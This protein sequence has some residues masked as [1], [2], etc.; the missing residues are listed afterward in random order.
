MKS[1]HILFRILI[2]VFLSMTLMGCPPIT[3]PTITDEAG[4]IYMQPYLAEYYTV[5]LDNFVDQETITVP[6]EFNGLPITEVGQINVSSENQV[7]HIILPDTI[8]SISSYAFFGFSNLESIDLPDSVERIG[9]GAF[10]NCSSLIEITIPEGVSTLSHNIFVGCISLE[11][12]SLPAS[13]STIEEVSF[14]Q[15]FALTEVDIAPGN[16]SFLFED[17]MIFNHDKSTLVVYLPSN[18]LEEFSIP[19][20]VIAIADCAFMYDEYLKSVIISEGVETIGSN[21]FGMMLQ[22]NTVVIS[23]S[24]KSI[25]N[26]A[27][28]NSTELKYVTLN[29]GLQVIGTN[30]FYMCESLETIQIP[31]SVEIINDNAFGYCSSLQRLTVDSMS[32][33]FES[34]EGVLY[35]KDLQV[36]LIYPAGIESDTFVIPSCVRLVLESSFESNMYLRTLIISS[37][38]TTIEMNAFA[39]CFLLHEVYIP[40]SVT[41]IEG[42]AFYGYSGVT[43]YCEANS[44]PEGWSQRWLMSE[45]TVIWGWEG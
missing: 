3:Q 14:V 12:V 43:F 33:H 34:I 22:L 16:V 41:E 9:S 18:K 30:A 1:K 11:K 39:Y 10:Q 4:F 25:G 38:V 24:V 21:A 40:L 32:G 26:S 29:E 20:G 2:V 23:G 5:F 13:L 28:Q 7:K 44:K 15:C 27:F 8:V 6:S 36:L 42:N 31:A 45:Q 17:N 35:T 19:S 37:G